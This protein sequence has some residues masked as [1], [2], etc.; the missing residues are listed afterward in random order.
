M[1]LLRIILHVTII[2]ISQ[3]KIPLFG[4]SKTRK[5][6]FHTENLWNSYIDMF[7]FKYIR[8]QTCE[9]ASF[10]HIVTYFQYFSYEFIM[11]SKRIIP[12]KNQSVI[13]PASGHIHEWYEK[14][15]KKWSERRWRFYQRDIHYHIDYKLSLNITFI[16][17]NFNTIK[18]KNSCN[19]KESMLLIKSIKDSI[20]DHKYCG[21]YSLFYHYSRFKNIAIQIA[22]FADQQYSINLIFSVIDS[23]FVY[24]VKWSQ[25]QN[26][27]SVIIPYHQ[28]L[29]KR[30]NLVTSYLIRVPK[31]YRI[32]FEKNLFYKKDY[33]IFDGPSFLSNIIKT[34]QEQVYTSLFVCIVQFLHI[35]YKNNNSLNFTAKQLQ[36]LNV[37][38]IQNHPS[39]ITFNVPNTKC[40]YNL[41]LTCFLTSSELQV[42]LTVFH[43]VGAGKYTFQCPEGGILTME[44][45]NS[46]YMESVVLCEEHDGN[47]VPSRSFYSSNSSLI[48]M[49]YWFGKKINVSISITL[50]RCQ[51]VHIEPC[52]YYLLTCKSAF[53]AK[54]YLKKITK[55]SKL[56][57]IQNDFIAY[58]DQ[59][60]LILFD[61]SKMECAVVQV[62][63]KYP[64][65]ET[66][67]NLT[68]YDEICPIF[69]TYVHSYC[70][71]VLSPMMKLG[72]T[73]S[74]IKGHIH[75]TAINYG[76]YPESSGSSKIEKI[77][78]YNAEHNSVSVRTR[79][80]VWSSRYWIDLKI[81]GEYNPP[82]IL[83]RRIPWDTQINDVRHLLL[84]GPALYFA[85]DL[86]LKIIQGKHLRL[87]INNT[88]EVIYQ[89]QYIMKYGNKYISQGEYL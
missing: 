75:R 84:L 76:S 2:N 42:N 1:L 77:P 67:F 23:N 32:I 6:M 59:E 52:V 22:D 44:H 87:N 53:H 38:N 57:L 60:N 25:E 71:I 9:T 86:N 3:G 31:I 49:M 89:K 15:S 88:L 64:S 28:Y 73:I 50:T 51:P 36:I 40:K 62:G 11:I 43:I 80:S 48:L 54:D 39:S 74:G 72:M 58:Y 61:T 56:Q 19:A 41:C 18:W 55:F 45:L 12:F 21:V 5:E 83:V 68:E 24:S 8:N 17:I 27:L 78:N 20:N 35:S 81:S 82:A 66:Y 13:K 65:Y 29:I 63:N 14:N 70:D 4:I 85:A 46:K 47:K 34:K 30:T 10:Q 79:F 16:E 69:H 7:L 37:V 33:V 26:H